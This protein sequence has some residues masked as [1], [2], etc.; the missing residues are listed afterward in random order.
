MLGQGHEHSG[1][2]KK[3]SDWLKSVI[4]RACSNRGQINW[5]GITC[6][7]ELNSSYI[8][9]KLN[10]GYRNPALNKLDR[11]PEYKPRMNVQVK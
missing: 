3:T 5:R 11:A 4:G 6:K 9:A 2:C 8:H 1:G 10:R 7:P